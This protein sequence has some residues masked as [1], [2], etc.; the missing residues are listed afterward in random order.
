MF[1]SILAVLFLIRL[2]HKFNFYAPKTICFSFYCY[3][4]MCYDY[5]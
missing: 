4:L 5:A 2:F 3:D 1:S